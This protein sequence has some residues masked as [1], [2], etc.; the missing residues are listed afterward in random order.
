MSTPITTGAPT[1]VYPEISPNVQPAPSQPQESSLR[2]LGGTLQSA[3]HGFR[4]LILKVQNVVQM[5][6]AEILGRLTSIA[7]CFDTFSICIRNLEDAF[8]PKPVTSPDLMQ[9]LKQ[10][11]SSLSFNIDPPASQVAS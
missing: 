5:I 1:S 7:S 11:L 2:K 3:V 9:N 10:V 6:F 4:E 8:C